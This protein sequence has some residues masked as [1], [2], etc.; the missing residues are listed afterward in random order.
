MACCNLDS[1]QFEGRDVSAMIDFVAGLSTTQLDAPRRPADGQ[2]RRSYG[3]AIQFVTAAMD[4]RVD[5]LAPQIAFNNLQSL[6]RP[7]R[8]RPVVVCA[9]AA[10]ELHRDGRQNQPRPRP[11][12]LIGALTGRVLVFAQPLVDNAGPGALTQDVKVPTLLI[13]GIPDPIFPLEQSMINARML[14]ANGVPLKM[15]WLLRRPRHLP[16]SPG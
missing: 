7:I 2:G 12:I 13:Q 5:A 1:A 16:D 4:S 8:R 3:G 6:L 14:E 10:T 15:I 9:A 11:G